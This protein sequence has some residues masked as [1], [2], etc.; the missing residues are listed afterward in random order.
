MVEEIPGQRIN[1]Y[2]HQKFRRSVTVG[3]LTNSG[4]DW[5]HTAEQ[6]RINSGPSEKAN[7]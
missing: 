4:Q 5:M 6:F 1:V 2:P 3:G 7:W